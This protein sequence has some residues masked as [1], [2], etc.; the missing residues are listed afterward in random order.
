MIGYIKGIIIEKSLPF[1]LIDV[2][3]LGYEV[4]V[5]LI[6]FSQTPAEGTTVTLYTHLSI[7]EDAHLL[8]GFYN[9]SE[10]EWFR[11]LIKINGVGPKLALSILS[12]LNEQALIH[13][14]Q[15]QDVSV[16]TRVP[17][18]GKKTAARL[19]V[20]MQGKLSHLNKYCSE[21]PLPLH[22]GDITGEQFADNSQQE[23][24]DA[25]SALIALG[26]KQQDASQAVSKIK[27]KDK[28]AS[29]QLIR[30]ALQSMA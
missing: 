23:I 10:R 11:E 15:E 1:L 30:Q 17:G 27:S 7:R 18:I 2:S 26:Y 8:Y 22:G 5:S 29:D 28:L 13:C 19:L 3:G 25:I 21:V 6:T 9:K 16:L 4:Q 24:A 12:V 20:E 14:V